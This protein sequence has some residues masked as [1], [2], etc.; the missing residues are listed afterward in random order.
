LRKTFDYLNLRFIT[1][2]DESLSLLVCKIKLFDS[3][4][5]QFQLQSEPK[6]FWYWI[7]H[8]KWQK[9]NLDIPREYLLLQLD[10]FLPDITL[11]NYF[12]ITCPN[13]ESPRSVIPH[14]LTYQGALQNE[15][16]KWF[17]IDNPKFCNLK[18]ELE[19]YL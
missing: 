3:N 13:P 15:L 6:V 7:K 2:F 14:P 11:P 9:W 16:F 18:S 1:A 8:M 10:C 19:L 12:S 4:L 5:N 17:L